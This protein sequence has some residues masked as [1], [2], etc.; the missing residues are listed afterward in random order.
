V[1]DDIDITTNGEGIAGV[2]AL[3]KTAADGV[4]MR[5]IGSMSL[6]HTLFLLG[7]VDRRRVMVSR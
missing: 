6:V 5:A 4:A 3:L 2:N 7:L 1:S